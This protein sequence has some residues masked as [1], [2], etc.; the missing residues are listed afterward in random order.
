MSEGEILESERKGKIFK[1]WRLFI[2]RT[3][4]KR[5]QNADVLDV[6]TKTSLQGASD[7]R[8]SNR[9]L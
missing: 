5:R 2:Q 4:Q 8:N 1:F 7:D 9:Y 3:Q 6:Q